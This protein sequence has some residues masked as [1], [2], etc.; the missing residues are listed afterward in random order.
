[1]VSLA[2]FYLLLITISRI[3]ASRI[4][5]NAMLSDLLTLLDGAYRIHSGQIIHRDFS[6]PLG[7]F[8][9]ALPA[10]F[11]SLGIGLIRSFNY[12]EAVF[13]VIAFL[14]Y[15]YIQRT[16]LD[17]MAGFF[18]GVWIPLALLARMNFGDPIEFFTEAMQYNRR[19]DVFFATVAS[20]IHSTV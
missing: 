12:G 3:F 20:A 2:L 19:C 4:Y 16:R 1:M 5:N 9:Y 18:L 8:A 15:L 6:S 13:V 11:M 10:A 14:L 17:A 7:L